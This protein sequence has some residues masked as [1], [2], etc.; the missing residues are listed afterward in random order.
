MSVDYIALHMMHACMLRL[1]H[2]AADIPQQSAAAAA[3]AEAD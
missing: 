1:Q 3:A 2:A